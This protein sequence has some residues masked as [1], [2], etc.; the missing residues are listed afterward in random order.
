MPGMS[1]TN[2]GDGETLYTNIAV[3]D[4]PG[5]EVEIQGE[6]PT[7]II[8]S[9]RSAAI[10]KLGAD[11]EIPGFRKG[12]APE[13]MLADHL[14]ESAIMFEI[15]E[16]VLGEAYP[17][18]VQEHKLDVVDM[19][20]ISIT[21]LAPGNPVGF[22]AVSAV[23][24]KIELPDYKK[25]A[26]EV[27]K[28]NPEEEVAVTDEEL[29]ETLTQLRRNKAQIAQQQK[30]EEPTEE[31]KDEDLPELTD[32]DVKKLGDFTDLDDFRTKVRTNMKQVKE[33]KQKEAFR[34]KLLDALYEKTTG[35]IPNVFIEAE[36]DKIMHEFRHQLTSMGLQ[37]EDYL[38]RTEKTEETL[39]NDSRNEA[40]KRAKLQLILG[41]IA[42]ADGITPD[43]EKVKQQVSHILEHH[44][45]VDEDRV[46]T[47][48]ETMLANE[49]VLEMLETQA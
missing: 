39:R 27:R 4:L 26:A 45:D 5:S 11:K 17:Q 29:N 22:T 41:E 35:D 9:R 38:K 8:A 15:A 32:E 24:P 37:F 42:K 7:D 36:L 18:I 14:G 28:E 12:H 1:Q 49:M 40:E 2:K 20:Q 19:P 33:Q 23:M 44:K 46:K 21:K 43:E 16:T 3:K 13:D 30:G 47:Y 48:V 31:I 10:K 6:I 25:V 34:G